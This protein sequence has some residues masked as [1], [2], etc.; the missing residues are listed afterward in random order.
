MKGFNSTSFKKA[1][2]SITE[3][4][5][6][7]K[8]YTA[9]PKPI[10]TKRIKI[11]SDKPHV[12]A[13]ST[14]ESQIAEHRAKFGECSYYISECGGELLVCPKCKRKVC[15]YHSSNLSKN[16]YGFSF[17]P[18]EQRF[19]YRCHYVVMSAINSF[20]YVAKIE[21]PSLQSSFTNVSRRLTEAQ[22]KIVELEAA[23]AKKVQEET[24]RIAR[25]EFQYHETQRMIES[26]GR[27]I[28]AE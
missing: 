6:R 20:E 25:L 16:G 13:D 18:I 23:L 19:C 2:Q 8:R 17:L 5:N 10:K 9:P 12:E 7:N 3:L 4:K 14:R 21:F 26:H 11:W 27:V 22:K 1:K 28:D 24:E 15:G